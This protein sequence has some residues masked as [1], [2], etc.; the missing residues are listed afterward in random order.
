MLFFFCCDLRI[1]WFYALLT[2]SIN[3]IM[4]LTTSSISYVDEPFLTCKTPALRRIQTHIIRI[5]FACIS[6]C[7]SLSL[8]VSFTHSFDSA[9]LQRRESRLSFYGRKIIPYDFFSTALLRSEYVRIDNEY[10]SFF[11]L[12]FKARSSGKNVFHIKRTHYAN[13]CRV[14]L[15]C[16]ATWTPT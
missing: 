9:Y 3:G 13:D 4:L 11:F 15:A 2:V 6:P 8:S 16:L 10:I 1:P 14:V 5:I 12:Q 7:V